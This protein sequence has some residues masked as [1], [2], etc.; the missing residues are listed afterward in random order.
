MRIKKFIGGSAITAVALAAVVVLG[1]GTPAAAA[2]YASGAYF[3]H[4]SCIAAQKIN[5]AQGGIIVRSCYESSPG[6]WRFWYEI[7]RNSSK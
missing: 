4:S 3:S 7:G 6:L 2:R 5:D 1:T